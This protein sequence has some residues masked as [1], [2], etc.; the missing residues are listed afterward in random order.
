MSESPDWQIPASAATCS[1]CQAGLQ[2]GDAVTVVLTLDAAGP[3]RDDLCGRCEQQAPVD[4]GSLYWKRRV[5]A[6]AAAR[7]VVDYKLLRE[8]FERLLQRSEPVYQRLAYLVGLVLLRKRHV[9]LR[10]FEV[11]DGREV[12]VVARA[13]D[14]P[15]LVVPAPHLDAAELVET[16]EQLT[17]LL[18]TDLPSDAGSGVGD[19]W[20]LPDLQG[21]P[22]Q[23]A[24]SDADAGAE[25]S[26]P[27]AA[28][29]EAAPSLERGAVEPAPP[30]RRSGGRTRRQPELN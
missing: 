23:P 21:Q 24:E 26:D 27:A 16:R 9:R 20:L 10:G 14:Q 8:I 22:Q 7:P 4:P 3:R 19:D 17:R 2:E 11:R 12:M 30:R 13:V 28:V 29:P 15:E 1:R 25:R 18:A 5:P 6:R